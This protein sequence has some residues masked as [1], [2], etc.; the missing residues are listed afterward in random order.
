[1]AKKKGFFEN[2]INIFDKKL[3]KKSKERKCGKDG[4]CCG[5]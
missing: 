4:G 5:K 2:L 1:M 3:E